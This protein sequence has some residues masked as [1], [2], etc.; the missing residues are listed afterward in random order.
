MAVGGA[1]PDGRADLTGRE[2]FAA[3]L[4]GEAVAFV[5]Y[6]W[7]RLPE[8]VHQPATEWWRDANQARRLLVDAASLARADAMVIDAC[9]DALQAV[10]ARGGGIDQLDRFA[11]TD[12]ARDAFSLLDVLAASVPF[13]GVARLPDL[14]TFAMSLGDGDPEVGEVAEDALSDLARACLEARA[15]A[16]LVMGTDAEVVRASAGRIASVAE[17]YGRPLL[18]AAAADAWLE[19]SGS[20]EVRILEPDGAWPSL[21]AGVVLT[22]DVSARWDAD[23]LAEVGRS[24]R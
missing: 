5:P 15:D 6:V 2:R 18:V 3:A 13:A 10:A 22:Q 17:Y 8:F 16:L 9:R 7:E 1:E 21:G 23:R 14:E 20:V 12:E 11:E 24:A 4:R 19:G